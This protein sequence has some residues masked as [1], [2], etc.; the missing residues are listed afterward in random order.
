MDTSEQVLKLSAAMVILFE[1]GEAAEERYKGSRQLLMN[2][3]EFLGE[4]VNTI[5]LLE[6]RESGDLL[7]RPLLETDVSYRSETFHDDLAE[8]EEFLSDMAGQ[9]A[10]EAAYGVRKAAEIVDEAAE[11]FLLLD[12]ANREPANEIPVAPWSVISGS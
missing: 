4:S 12:R 5:V 8:L 9:V 6:M 2:A 3:M 1:F 10:R 7:G 11:A